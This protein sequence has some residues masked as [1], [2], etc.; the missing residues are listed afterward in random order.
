MNNW[1]VQ[2]TVLGKW[3][4]MMLKIYPDISCATSVHECSRINTIKQMLTNSIVLEATNCDDPIVFG[5][6]T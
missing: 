1:R 5:N 4:A 2:K 3:S 6:K